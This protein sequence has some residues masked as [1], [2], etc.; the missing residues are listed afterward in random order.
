VPEGD[1]EGEVAG[2]EGGS[3]E[4]LHWCGRSPVTSWD[5]MTM[6]VAA[7]VVVRGRG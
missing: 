3:G 6:S 7:V 1:G 5:G 2:R 4:L